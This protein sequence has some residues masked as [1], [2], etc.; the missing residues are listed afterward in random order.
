MKGIRKLGKAMGAMLIRVTIS[1]VN[2]E[3]FIE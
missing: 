1:K 3:D 2:C